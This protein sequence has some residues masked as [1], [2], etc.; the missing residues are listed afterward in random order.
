MMGSMVDRNE[1]AR[2]LKQLSNAATLEEINRYGEG[3]EQALY[4]WA[5]WQ[6]SREEHQRIMDL[7][8]TIRYAVWQT[9][10]DLSERSSIPEKD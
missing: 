10:C 2:L 8:L 1:A 3:Y 9:E 5:R 6:H 7:R 4:Q